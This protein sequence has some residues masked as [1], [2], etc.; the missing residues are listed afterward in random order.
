M[1]KHA[2]QHDYQRP[3][4]LDLALLLGGP[5]HGL[6]TPGSHELDC[7][8]VNHFRK[9]LTTK[10]MKTSKAILLRAKG[11]HRILLLAAE[12]L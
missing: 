11:H 8:F 7:R 5:R 9:L 1:M 12:Q 2:F 3:A 4:A 6:P 10:K